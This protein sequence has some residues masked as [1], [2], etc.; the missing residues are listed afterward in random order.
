MTA[1]LRNNQG[2]Q[3]RTTPCVV[4]AWVPCLAEAAATGRAAGAAAKADVISAA[5]RG[6]TNVSDGCQTRQKPA[7]AAIEASPPAMSTSS[8]PTKLLHAY[9]TIAN[10]PPQTSTAGQ[11][12]RSPAQPLIVATSQAG[13]SSETNGS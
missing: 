2:T 9:C 3:A 13:T 1:T 6:S 8:T 4:R 10:V 12:A 11:T 5:T 7:S